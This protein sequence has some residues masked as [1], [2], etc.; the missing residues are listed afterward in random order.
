[1]L[2]LGIE[3]DQEGVAVAE[4]SSGAAVE[5]GELVGIERA[6][7]RKDPQRRGHALELAIDGGRDR[8][9]RGLHQR[10]DGR[11]LRLVV[12]LEEDGREYETGNQRNQ[13][14]NKQIEPDGGWPAHRLGR[15]R[16]RNLGHR[17]P[18]TSAG[19]GDREDRRE[20]TEAQN[21]LLVQNP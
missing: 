12:A 16:W 9:R 15:R 7:S 1:L 6:R 18:V 4:R 13:T 5:L 14:Q 19:P 10:L 2:Q 11:L 8:L 21:P 17:K 20:R 3:N